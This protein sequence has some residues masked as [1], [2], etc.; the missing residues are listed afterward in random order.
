MTIFALTFFFVALAV[1]G[2]AVGVI[3]TGRRLPGSCGGTE[4]S[5]EC[6]RKGIAPRCATEPEGPPS[7]TGHPRLPVAPPNDAGRARR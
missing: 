4:A 2:M 6:L 7:P 1:L 3:V 5:C